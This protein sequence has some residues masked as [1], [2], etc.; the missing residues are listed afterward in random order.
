MEH[1]LPELI[2]K[3]RT[4]WLSDI[5]LG[6]RDC[7]VD[8][9]LHFIKHTD[10]EYLFFVG[11]IIDFWALTRTPYWPQ[12]HNTFIQKILKKSRHGTRV[13]YIPGNHDENLRDFIG[14]TLGGIE[15]HEDY[16]HT[17]ITG[18]NIFC[19]HGDVFDVITRCHRWIAV[20]GDIGYTWLLWINR[21]Q[22]KLRRYFGW[23]YWSF[24]AYIKYK[25]KEAVSFIGDYEKNVVKEAKHLHVDGVLCGHIHHPEIRV[26][27]DILYLNTGDVVESCSA[28]AEKYTGELVLLRFANNTITETTTYN[29]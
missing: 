25:V 16:T 20:L 29:F 23:D 19:L 14:T 10:S 11:D 3:Y 18:Q 27:D 9:L 21:Y 13:I 15:L 5:H 12:S 2:T 4:I 7:Q 8:A 22:N 17:L 28:I 1:L 24:S 6:T 26:I